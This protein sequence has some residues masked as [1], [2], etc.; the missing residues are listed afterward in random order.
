MTTNR[1]PAPAVARAIAQL[2]ED[3]SKARRRRR[4]SRASLAERSGVS[5]ATLKRLEKG[6]GSVALENFARACTCSASSIASRNCSTAA[7]MN[8]DSCSWTSNC[9]SV[10]ASDVARG[11]CE[12]TID[13][14]TDDRMRR[15]L[16]HRRRRSH[17]RARR[18]SRIFRLHL[19]PIVAHAPP[20]FEVSPDLPLREGHFTRRAPSDE[21]RRSPPRSPTPN[22]TCGASASSSARMPSNA[23]AILRSRR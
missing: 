18:P 11:H 7:R 1:H 8:W 21:D 6:D 16:G 19:R 12:R 15:T 13:Q 17:V 23:S 2:G 20:A 4:L 22:P 3:L 5:E 14:T 9:R 10:C